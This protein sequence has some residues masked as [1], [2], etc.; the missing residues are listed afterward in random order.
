M[1]LKELKLT[2]KRLEICERLGLHDSGEIL[3][4]YPF[5]Y[6]YL[7][8]KHYRDFHEGDTVCFEGELITYPS[9]F[10]Y[11][12]RSTT[13]FK[14]LYE[15]EELSI[16]I[17]NRPWIRNLDVNETI[18]IIGKYDGKNKVTA[19]NYYA[20]A[21]EEVAGIIPYY[22]LKEG[23]GQNEIRK[24]IE[25]VW[26]KTGPSLEDLMPASLVESHHLISYR[27]AVHHIH[28]PA[29]K[30]ELAQALSRLKYEEFLRFYLA[31]NILKDSTGNELKAKK[32]F[33]DEEVEELI[34]R[35]PFEL[36][37][38]QRD[39]VEEILKDLR[40]DKI[41]VRL[42]QGDVGSGKT[43]VAMI[44]LYANY[45]AGY[46]GALMAPTEIL[47]RQHY[48]SLKEILEP[49]GVHV[50]VIYSA[51]ENE[52]TVKEMVR[53]GE[54]DIVVGTHA[55]FS[56]DVEFRKLGLVIADE[57]QRFGVKQR[58]KLREKG[59]N[60]DFLLMSATPIPRTLASAVY[61]DMEVSSIHT[62]P[63]GRK[64]CRTYMIGKNSVVSILP[65]LKRKLE[66]G[67]QIYIIA[68][69]IEKNE[70]YKAKDV[71][72]LYNGLKEVLS[73]FKTAL[74]HGR[75]DSVEKDEVMRR[76]NENEVQVLISTTVVEVGVNVKN[77]TVMVIYDADK[78][79]LS[80]LHQLRGRI[81]RGE[82]EGTCYLLSDSKDE[83]VRKRL[84]V[85]CDTNDGFEISLQDLKLRGPGDILGTRQSGLPALILGN[86]LEDQRFI[87]AARK[88]ARDLYEHKDLPENKRYYE[89]ILEAAA[90]N[91][92]D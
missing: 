55:L 25:A 36:T 10:R 77:A 44:A 65:E 30:M 45:L 23:I 79:G 28:F 1:D 73:P 53:Y 89:R 49:L 67:R 14:V 90:K 12:K 37:K 27:E 24:L 64:G 20:K 92:I 80:Q 2:A 13:R 59:E 83:N 11:G 71:T 68:A 8:A 32:V 26:K 18:T 76:F 29:S 78:F 41:M 46:Q 69:A 38:D 31:M 21:M 7:E 35:L 74:L 39:A 84:Q 81:Q 50:S 58:K 62:M 17:Y 57:Q 4:Y 91:Y 22:P 70:N 43:A 88:D 16:T 60:S 34:S 42:L 19:S 33:D 66:E 54:S 75:M 61:G 47:A 63:K 86:L 15:E 56:D 3:S 87:E 40:S 85:L 82:Y 6:D 72:G 51:M 9:T 48:R 5:R 52:K